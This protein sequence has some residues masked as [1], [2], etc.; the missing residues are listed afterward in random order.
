MDTSFRVRLLELGRM[1][2]YLKYNTMLFLKS[3]CFFFN[4]FITTILRD[5]DKALYTMTNDRPKQRLK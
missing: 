2:L 4:D 1:W 3:K 5:V